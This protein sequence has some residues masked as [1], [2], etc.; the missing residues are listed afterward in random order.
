MFVMLNS[1]NVLAYNKRLIGVTLVIWPLK[2]QQ[3]RIIVYNRFQL[4]IVV[5]VYPCG[6]W[7][8][9]VTANNRLFQAET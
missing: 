8:I 5:D 1:C 6:G 4:K 2:A 9:T 7:I 3:S